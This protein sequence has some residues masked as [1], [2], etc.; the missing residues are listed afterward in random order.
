MLPMLALAC[1]SPAKEPLVA[2]QA[3]VT[4]APMRSCDL[5][6]ERADAPSF[7]F[8]SARLSERG[9]D[10]VARIA[11][12]YREGRIGSHLLIVGF[13][14][15]RGPSDYNRQLGIY[16]AIAMRQALVASGVPE[17]AMTVVSRGERDAKGDDERGWALDRRVEIRF[18]DER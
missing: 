2:S 15:A 11:A 14:D 1:A 7:D 9:R 17:S 10:V 6:D 5:P 8:D 13:T 12:C 16:R 18:G 3:E 4:S